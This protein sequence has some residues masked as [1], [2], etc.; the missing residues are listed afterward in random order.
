MKVFGGFAM[1]D[2]LLVSVD[3]ARGNVEILM[4]KCS[5]GEE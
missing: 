2:G 3:I 4:S 5:C 1:L